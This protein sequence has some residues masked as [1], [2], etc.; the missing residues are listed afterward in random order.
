[1]A[2]R[3]KFATYTFLRPG[4]LA[5]LTRHDQEPLDTD[6]DRQPTMGFVR[7]LAGVAIVL[8]RRIGEYVDIL[9]KSEESI[10]ALRLYWRCHFHCQDCD[11]WLMLAGHIE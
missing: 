10:S 6:G 9:E 5:I 1:M 4:K 11:K 2:T 7:L 8:Q 3:L